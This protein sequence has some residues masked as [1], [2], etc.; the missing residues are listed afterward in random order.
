MEKNVLWRVM[1]N[2]EL[3][4]MVLSGDRCE[5]ISERFYDDVRL[6]VDDKYVVSYPMCYVKDKDSSVFS[7]IY[8]YYHLRVTFN[9]KNIF[10]ICSLRD[11]Y[12][13]VCRSIGG[14]RDDY[15][16]DGRDGLK[17]F[18]E[19]L[20]CLCDRDDKYNTLLLEWIK[21]LDNGVNK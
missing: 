5:D 20:D 18:L 16:V 14:N 15:L 21:L 9:D 1:E 19:F 8:P 17:E 7:T 6:Y 10:T 2:D 13:H 12:Y 11:S 4:S 3:I